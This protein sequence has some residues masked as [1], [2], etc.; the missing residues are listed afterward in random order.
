M[1]IV[2]A[3]RELTTFDHAVCDAQAVAHHV[4]FQ[5]LVFKR[6]SSFEG[7]YVGSAFITLW[8]AGIAAATVHAYR[9]RPALTATDRGWRWFG[10]LMLALGIVSIVVQSLALIEYAGVCR[11]L[12]HRS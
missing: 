5:Y 1:D 11:S 12:L 10:P 2:T 8:F 7:V 4:H 9:H 6:N 3:I